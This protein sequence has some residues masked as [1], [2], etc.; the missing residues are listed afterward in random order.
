[1]MLMSYLLASHGIMPQWSRWECV[2]K[3]MSTGAAGIGYEGGEDAVM[4]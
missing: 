1:M 2:R 4:P 3:A